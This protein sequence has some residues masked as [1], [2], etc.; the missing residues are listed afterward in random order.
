MLINN[1]L[2]DVVTRF[3]CFVPSAIPDTLSAGGLHVARAEMARPYVIWSRTEFILA[4]PREY[5]LCLKKRP[6][7]I[8]WISQSHTSHINNFWYRIISI[9]GRRFF[10]KW[11]I[12]LFNQLL[13]YIDYIQNLTP[14]TIAWTVSSQLNYDFC[15]NFF[16]TLAAFSGQPW[17]NDM[18]S[19]CLS[20]RI[21]SV[22]SGSDVQLDCCCACASSRQISID[23]CRRRHSSAAGSVSDVIRG[24]S[25]PTYVPFIFFRFWSACMA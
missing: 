19:V 8:F 14:P 4:L 12:K 10:E 25:T 2:T 15:F 3:E 6:C 1:L 21:A 16:L 23:M 20:H 7:A 5:T 17:C 11:C 9:K 18:V 22:V 13:D 24:G